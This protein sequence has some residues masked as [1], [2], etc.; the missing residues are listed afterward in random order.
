VNPEHLELLQKPEWN[1]WRSARPAFTPDEAANLVAAHR[2][3]AEE[4]IW[5]AVESAAA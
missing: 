2:C 4:V 1:E 3:R 5:K